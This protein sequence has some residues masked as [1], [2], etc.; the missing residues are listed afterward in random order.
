MVVL[1]VPGLPSYKYRRPESKPPLRMESSA[2]LPVEIRG[3][4]ISAD[5][6]EASL[7]SAFDIAMEPQRW[8]GGLYQTEPEGIGG[9]GFGFPHTG[10]ASNGPKNVIP[11]RTFIQTWLPRRD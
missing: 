1:P 8:G 3:R 4:S 5:S 11:R 10:G 7:T 6:S 9:F 2:S